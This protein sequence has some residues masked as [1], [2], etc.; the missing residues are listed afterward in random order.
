MNENKYPSIKYLQQLLNMTEKF[1]YTIKEIHALK[2]YIK[3][4]D[5]WL[6]EAE[7]LLLR[8]KR[9]V[10]KEN[11]KPRS[12]D[13]IRI[14]ISKADIYAFDSME[15]KS[16]RSLYDSVINFQVNVSEFLRSPQ[17]KLSLNE[18]KEL[19]RK[20]RDL[21]VDIP[22]M[23]K[24]ELLHENLVWRRESDLVIVNGE[25]EADY[26]TVN[27]LIEMAKECKIPSDNKIF[28]DL[29]H[30]KEIADDWKRRA[31]KLIAQDEIDLKDLESI[32]DEINDIP[33]IEGL[34][35]DLH[36]MQ[37][38]AEDYIKMA[39]MYLDD[40]ENDN[41]KNQVTISEEKVDDKKEESIN[42]EIEKKDVNNE[43]SEIKTEESKNNEKM[44]L[45]YDDE[46]NDNELCRCFDNDHEEDDVTIYEDSMD[47]GKDDYQKIKRNKEII[48]SR[49][50]ETSKYDLKFILNNSPSD[51]DSKNDADKVL[52]SEINNLV[53]NTIHDAVDEIRKEPLVDLANTKTLYSGS[54]SSS[55]NIIYKL[56]SKTIDIPLW[57]ERN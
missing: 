29:C 44:Q 25:I 18:V 36:N 57:K 38:K 17:E 7:T 40:D 52:N 50:K 27:H 48:A 51:I 16:L 1:P 2:R 33:N 4:V 47:I 49:Q 21:D 43:K 14:L 6:K 55:E 42:K 37:V 54:N 24:L 15:I 34:M 45:P 35:E 39:K 56:P 31:E 10:N 28:L 22:E 20:G 26:K 30:E 5:I 3:V 53:Y 23:E 41:I 9:N 19:V 46:E 12:L 11:L 8:D 13:Q 32:L